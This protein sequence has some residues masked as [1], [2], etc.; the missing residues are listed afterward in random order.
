[1]SLH[2]KKKNHC[3]FKLFS[4]RYQSP[5]GVT[6]LVLRLRCLLF[7]FIPLSK[8][9]RCHEKKKKKFSSR[10]QSPGGVTKLNKIKLGTNLRFSS[11]YQSPGGVTIEDMAIPA[12]KKRF[13]PVIKVRAVSQGVYGW[14]AGLDCFHPVIKVRAVSRSIKIHNQPYNKSFHPVIK[15]RAV[16][17]DGLF[18]CLNEL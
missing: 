3:I 16:S 14:S 5:G 10:Y 9:G 11:R 18:H 4:S 1:M 17:R 7:V 6:P 15:V 12:K 13:H 2:L 8:S